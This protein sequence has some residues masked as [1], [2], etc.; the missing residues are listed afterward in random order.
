MSFGEGVWEGCGGVLEFRVGGG[1]NR[2]FV[3]C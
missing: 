2:V 1:Y 3:L